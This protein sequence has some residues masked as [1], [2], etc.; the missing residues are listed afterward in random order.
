[1]FF[2]VFSIRDSYFLRVWAQTEGI[3][4]FSLAAF[5]VSLLDR[6]YCLV[7]WFLWI[8]A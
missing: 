2:S 8:L 5:T 3:S 7:S 4:D 6:D 1:M